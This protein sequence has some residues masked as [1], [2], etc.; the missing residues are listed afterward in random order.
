[1]SDSLRD[2]LLKSGLVKQLREER[3]QKDPRPNAGGG[4]RGGSRRGAKPGGAAS[5]KDTAEMDLARAYAMR[6]KVEAQERRR[7]QQEAQ[8]AARLR[9]ER[10]RKLQEALDGAALNKA[11]AELMR[12]FEYGGKIRRVHVD[13]DQLAALNAGELAVVQFG[14]RYLLVSTETAE[15]VRAIAP[16]QIALQVEPGAAGVGEDGVPDDL[17][18]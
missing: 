9:K 6:A 5:A 1:M 3:R 14:G 18:W 4:K 11:E 15:R 16:D 12:H 10:K 7:A 2:Q 17:V 8:E 13:A